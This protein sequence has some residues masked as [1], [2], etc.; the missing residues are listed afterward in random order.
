MNGLEL[1]SKQFHW[2]YSESFTND[3][4]VPGSSPVAGHRR[5]HAGHRGA[6]PDTMSGCLGIL[7]FG[8]RAVSSTVVVRSMDRES[9]PRRFGT[10][11]HTLVERTVDL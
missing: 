4:E 8:V 6:Y 11:H 2:V 3:Q 9:S 10:D 7:V 5:R 1:A